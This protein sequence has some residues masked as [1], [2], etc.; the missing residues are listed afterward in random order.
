MILHLEHPSGVP[1]TLLLAQLS[2]KPTPGGGLLL[3]RHIPPPLRRYMVYLMGWSAA[4]TQ[5]A[6]EV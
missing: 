2:M 3:H 1:R 5:P 6:A 4:F